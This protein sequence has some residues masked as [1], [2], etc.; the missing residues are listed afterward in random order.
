M[1]R[2]L[3]LVDDEAAVL[4]ALKR[5][6]RDRPYEVITAHSGA[7]GLALLEQHEVQVI[8]SDHRMPGM[9][10]VEFLSQVNERYPQTIR[11][12]LSGYADFDSLTDAINLGGIYQFVHKPWEAGQIVAVIN[13]AFAQFDLVQSAAVFARVFADSAEGIVIIDANAEIHSANPA[14]CAM[15]GYTATQLDGRPIATLGGAE[16]ETG[17]GA[18][19]AEVMAKNTAGN[20]APWRDE[21]WLQRNDGEL[22]PVAT[23]LSALVDP[24]GK[25]TQHVLLCNDITERKQKEI[26]LLESEKRFRDFMEF[27]PIGMVI[28][29]L[30][31]ELLKVNQAL[32]TIFAYPRD[33]LE[34]MRFEALTHPDDL[35]ADLASRR[36]LLSGELPHWQVE[37]RYLRKDGKTIWVQVSASLLRDIHGQ[38]QCFDV[39]IEDISQRRAQQEEIRRLAYYDVLTGLPNRRLLVDRL[40]QTLAQA[41]R[42][43]RMAAVLFVDLDHFKNVNDIHGHD[44]GDDLL[45]LAAQRLQACVRHADTVSRQGGDEFVL[46]LAEIA[47]L[48]GAVRVAEKI[49]ASVGQPYGLPARGLTLNEITASVGVAT[50]PSHGLNGEDLMKHADIAMYAAKAAGRND[51][52]VYSDDMQPGEPA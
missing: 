13:A 35:A 3:L 28:V 17:W 9:T 36:Q 37:R 8:V 5:E 40:E 38:P 4:N 33:E 29:G 51:F 23:S 32:C 21:L 34:Q 48:T 14:F 47:D 30:D 2:R 18:V 39:Q 26:A 27:A 19:L 1:K 45:K 50:F 41:R 49:V 11:L 22:F 24:I 16:W 6:L 15:T 7:E 20:A 43:Q 44:A 52:C 46:I 31:G 25:V 42:N 10:G 12:V